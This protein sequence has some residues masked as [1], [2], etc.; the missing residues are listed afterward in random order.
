MGDCESATF[1][2]DGDILLNIYRSHLKV[3]VQASFVY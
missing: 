2:G 3:L 1:L